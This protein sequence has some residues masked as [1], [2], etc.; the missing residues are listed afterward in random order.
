VQ[1]FVPRLPG[2]TKDA[3]A[4]VCCAILSH[5]SLIILLQDVI[6]A[7]SRRL[8]VRQA[9]QDSSSPFPVVLT[10]PINGRITS[11]IPIKL[12][13]TPT[14]YLFLTTDRYRYA[15]ISYSQGSTPYPVK[16]HASGSLRAS[17]REPAVGPLVSVDPHGR[18]LALHIYDGILTCIPIHVDYKP[19]IGTKGRAFPG[20]SL[21]GEPYQVRLEERAI[22]AIC[23]LHSS[24]EKPPHLCMLHQDSRNAQHIV[25]YNMDIRKKQLS[26]EWKKSRVDGGSSMLL[27]VP[28]VTA[29]AS[30]NPTPSNNNTAGVVVVGQRQI[31]YLAT[32][33]TKVVP[34][35]SCLILS[36]TYLP[37]ARYLLGDEFG[38]LHILTLQSNSME[39]ETLGSCNISSSLE[40]VQDGLVYVASCFGDSQL[41]QIHKEPLQPM[42][43][44][45]A[46]TFLEVVE[47]YTNLGP[48]VDFDLVPTHAQ[49]SQVVT[50]SGSSTSGSLRLVRN[51]IGMN[52]CASVEMEGIQ[53][54]WSIRKA[55]GEKQDAYLV[56][57]FVG[58][59]R[60]LGVSA[61]GDAMEEDGEEESE[62]GGT[63]EEIVLAGLDS[64]ASSLYV[65]NVQ[66]GNTI[67]QITESEIRL[68]AASSM[69][70][71]A[72][73]SPGAE[74]A[75]DAQAIT[76]AAANEAGQIVVSLRGG[77][78]LYLRVKDASTIEL[79]EKKTLE[80]EVSC[81]DLNPFVTTDGGS[82]MDLDGA[83]SSKLVAVGLWDDFTVRLLSLESGL[84]Q[85]LSVNLSTED[86][87]DVDNPEGTSRKARNNM[88]AG[89]LCL[90]TLDSANATSSSGSVNMLFV[91]LGDGTLVSFA[92]LERGGRLTANSRKEVNLGT[93]RI[94][95]VPLQTEQGGRCV[96]ATGDRPTVIYLAG[97]GGGAGGVF[98]NPKLCYS[99]VNLSTSDAGDE[100]DDVNRPPAQQSIAVNV[101]TPFVSP[102]LFD[103]SSAGAKHFSL[104]VS[105]DSNLRLGV[106]DDI[107]K[108]H[109]TT[110]RLGM[111][112][113]RVV[114]CSNDRMFAV[115]C[116][117]SG[118]NQ[119]GSVREDVNMGNCI[120]FLDD[121]TFDDIH[122]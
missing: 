89:S 19:P 49:Q 16:T 55:F 92:V 53:N 68:I 81:V 31:T 61:D 73:W 59:T 103:T 39:M 28:P 75:A 114:H 22:L 29:A 78:L 4:K 109:V 14:D 57:S 64:T 6:V 119:G 85:V 108:L 41:V 40:H 112:P 82:A 35:P 96:L 115:G 94:D 105:D 62:A 69:E 91:G 93:Q 66:V 48:I 5:Y 20:Q 37:H 70:V 30:R 76:V 17:G 101:A 100:D 90:I 13:G 46:S 32:G 106:I 110:C 8:E 97:G 11:M 99:N 102:Q 56:Q 42:N 60:V 15:V 44:M 80:S 120:R 122:R 87:E 52:E 116:I 33:M 36:A 72:T 43:D 47:E 38:N 83:S 3:R 121:T 21:L 77:V 25:T 51:G 98:S 86:E 26:V 71:T 18:C 107:Q 7:K 58:E 63:L 117:E 23:F 1:F 24:P 67:L 54:M 2:T 65:G 111:A 118:L 45:E 9:S 34:L 10:L 27:A 104:C 88:M 74:V 84:E 95:L 12:S 113:R 79:V 50:C